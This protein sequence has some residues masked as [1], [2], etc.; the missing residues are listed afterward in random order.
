MRTLREQIESKCIFFTGVLHDKCK[1]EIS[2]PTDLSALPCLKDK[3]PPECVKRR[4]PTEEEI[5]QEIKHIED[6]EKRYTSIYPI[7]AQ[8]KKSHANTNWSGSMECPVC[9]SELLLAYSAINGHVWGRCK[10]P[11]CIAWME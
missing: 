9:H 6:N 1:A 2:Y 7:I 4:W 8:I 5:T 3:N 11:N 10:T